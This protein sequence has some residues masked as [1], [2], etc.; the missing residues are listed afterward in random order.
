[1]DTGDSLYTSVV[2][3]QDV[4]YARTPFYGRYF[5]WLD[6]AWEWY[7]HRSDIWYSDVVIERR[8]GLPIV[9]IRC[10]Y[11]YP[12]RLDDQYGIAFRIDDL[13]SRGVQSRFGVLRLTDDI[14]VIAE[15]VCSRRFVAVDE[16]KG[17]EISPELMDVFEVL[18][19]ALG[20][21]WDAHIQSRIQ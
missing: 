16:F 12:L 9:D 8:I 17:T 13:S 18:Q 1:M 20:K 14:K 7:L 6:R 15:G 10:R 3:F 21:T 4:D 19:N 2:G 11:R 5:S